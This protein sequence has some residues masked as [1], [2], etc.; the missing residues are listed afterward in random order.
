MFF[1]LIHCIIQ[2]EIINSLSVQ[3]DILFYEVEIFRHWLWK[4]FRDLIQLSKLKVRK[5]EGCWRSL[6]LLP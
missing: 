3:N 4:Q 2:H 1:K 6:E 5:S